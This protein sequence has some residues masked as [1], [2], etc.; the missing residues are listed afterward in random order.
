MTGWWLSPTPLKNMSQLGYPIY[1][2]KIW[3]VKK[4]IFQTTNQGKTMI[5]G[6]LKIMFPGFN[7]VFALSY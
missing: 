2:G 4:I 3:K 7:A 6:L 5:L 1:Y